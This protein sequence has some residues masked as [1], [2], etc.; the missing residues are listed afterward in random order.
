MK[1]VESTLLIAWMKFY[2]DFRREPY[3]V[4]TQAGI[5]AGPLFFI[6]FSGSANAFHNGIV[7]AMISVVSF[8]GLT[9]AINDVAQD[10]YTKLREIMV[11]MPVHP[12]SYALGIA[13]AP[14][15]ASIP[16][17]LCFVALAVWLGLVNLA[18]IGILIAALT[19]SWLS[20]SMIGF[21]VSAYLTKVPPFMVVS[22]GHLLGLGLVFVPPVYYSEYALGMFSWVSYIFPTSNAASLIRSYLALSILPMESIILHWS[23]LIA[24]LLA[25]SL[26]ASF[27]TRWR[28]R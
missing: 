23:I 1:A 25:F 16:G 28:E 13:L 2:P 4:I 12:M 27:K 15:I 7:G 24:T 6:L 20:V 18:S 5:S 21:A 22:M 19:L 14:L 26:L 10:R 17:L 8:L 11:S 3:V 9:S